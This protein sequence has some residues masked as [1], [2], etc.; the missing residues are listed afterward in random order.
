MQLRNVVE[1]KHLPFVI[2]PCSWNFLYLKTSVLVVRVNLRYLF[3]DF[4][5][6][7]YYITG[8]P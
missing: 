4:V 7:P 3:I 6:D 5:G 2:D 1:S 8:A